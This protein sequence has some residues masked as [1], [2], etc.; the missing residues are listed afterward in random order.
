[1]KFKKLISVFGLSSILVLSSSLLTNCTS[2]ITEE[3]LMQ[4]QELRKRESQ[5]NMQISNKQQD[6]NKIQ[7]EINARK[8]EL[9]DCEKDREF[10]K[11]KLSQWPNVWPD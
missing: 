3:Q 6:I 11:Q 9:N 8:N 10:V 7:N 2:K 4:L 1:M 5:L